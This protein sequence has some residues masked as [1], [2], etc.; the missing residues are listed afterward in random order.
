MSSALLLSLAWQNFYLLPTIFFGLI[1]LFML[2]RKIRMEQPNA[3]L[4]VFVYTWLALL[5]WNIGSVW[6]IW[7]ASPGGAVAAFFI[8]SLPMV[9][10]FLLYHNRNVKTGTENFWY[11]IGLWIA[12][13]FLQF[14]WD[15]AF[16][17]LIL[18]NVFSYA[19][20]LVQW[21]EITGVLGGSFWIL[22][23]NIKLWQFIEAWQ[24]KRLIDERTKW[25][26]ALFIWVLLPIFASW[27]LM[28]TVNPKGPEVSVVVVQP[29]IDPYNEKFGGLSPEAQLNKMLKLAENAMDSQTQYIIL[30][31]T[32]L[33]GGLEENNLLN[34]SLFQI[35]KGFIA[36]HPGVKVIGGMDSYKIYEPNEP[37]SITA[38]K[39]RNSE[40]WYDSYNTAFCYNG[41]E[42]LQVYHKSKLV[43][44][45]EK[46]PYPQ[47]FG[48]IE[49]YAISLGG[50]S[51][52]L[53]QDKE[54]KVFG[55]SNQL[56]LA[57]IICYESVFPSYTSSYV[58]KG[59]DVLCVI[60][61]D[62]WWGNTPGFR[63]HFDF[64]RLRA[65]EN[66]RWVIRC[67]NTG[68]SGIINFKGRVVTET[69]WWKEVAFKAKVP[70]V[71]TETYYAKHGDWI[72]WV[73][74]VIGFLSTRFKPIV[75]TRFGN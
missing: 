14:H 30:P 54:S 71:Q 12:A 65:I 68:I 50:T 56:Q 7:N 10:P 22:M 64:S 55:F 28:P 59:A 58:Q 52:S 61:N 20:I 40:V 33:Q 13:E 48:F 38:R 11:F 51:G 36:V 2:E 66:R 29:N 37:K 24:E 19:P 45:V 9:L 57:P 27:Y 32:A 44:G 41:L 49:R 6:W 1:P 53:G 8:N 31:E 72:A 15:L 42:G 23:L 69:E 18:G 63:Q 34:E 47:I 67:A 17:W 26:N 25:M 4:W 73:L 74:M 60:T 75:L 70:L 3:K 46:M 35:L 21:F 43:P 39:A 5:V 62:G 16:P